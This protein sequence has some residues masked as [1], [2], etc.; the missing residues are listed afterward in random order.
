MILNDLVRQNKGFYLAI[1]GCGT[2][3][4]RSQGGTTELLLRN[5]DREFG[6]CILTLREHPNFQLN[7]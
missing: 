2:S 1:S 6:I 7:Y 4:Y 5:P 3:L